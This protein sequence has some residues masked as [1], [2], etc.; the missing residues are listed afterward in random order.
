VQWLLCLTLERSLGKKQLSSKNKIV[1][2]SD[3][4]GSLLSDKYESAEIEPILRRLLSLDVSIVLASSKT[5]AEIDF[6]RQKWPIRDPFVA[7]NG[8]VIIVPKNYFTVDYEFLNHQNVD[9]IELGTP[10]SIIREKLA[11]V[12]KQTGAE[13]VGF[14][15]MTVEDVAQDSSLPLYLAELAKKRE[16][17]EPFKIL[18][19]NVSQVLQA[20][21]NSGLSYVK[22]GRYLTAMGDCDK[23]KAVSIL[24]NLYLE[25]FKTVLTV[26]VGDSD[27]DLSMLA[28]VDKPFFVRNPSMIKSVWEEIMCLVEFSCK[29]QVA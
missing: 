24:K 26:G 5:R 28:T 4:D 20:V 22:G 3:L 15:D 18:N 25:Q 9:I 7:E 1:I 17:S 8:S 27:N 16:Y 21:I 2:F 23:G 10:Y 19:G 14:G 12:K 6:Y 13:I 29:H 11:D